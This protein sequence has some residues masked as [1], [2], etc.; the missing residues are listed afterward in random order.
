M[1]AAALERAPAQ[2]LDLYA[3]DSRTRRQR[4]SLRRVARRV[5]PLCAGCK[6]K[7]ARY[8]FRD[9]DLLEG[10]RTLCFECFR[11]EILRRQEQA[12]QLAR[13]RS[14]RQLELPLSERLNQIDRRRRRA[15]IAARHALGG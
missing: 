12:A 11:L 9:E 6:E 3:R 4:S 14:A 7:E 2:Q 10:S 8:G 15:Q 1:R 5:T 13:A